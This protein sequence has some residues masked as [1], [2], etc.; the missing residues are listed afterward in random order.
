MT[1]AIRLADGERVDKAYAGERGRASDVLLIALAAALVAA[2]VF[3]ARW[4]YVWFWRREVVGVSRD[5][6]WSAPL[7][8]LLVWMPPALLVAPLARWLPRAWALRLSGFAF[9]TLTALSV[10]IPVGGL[11]RPAVGVLA[12]GIGVSVGRGLAAST[13]ALTSMRALSVACALLL[14]VAS[15]AFPQWERSQRLARRAPVSAPPAGARNVLVIVLDAVRADALGAYGASRATSPHLD[16]LARGGVRFATAVATAPWTRPTHRSIFTG[17]YPRLWPGGASTFLA[18]MDSDSAP[19]LAEW[20]AAHGYATGAFVANFFYTGWDA[21]FAAGFVHYRDFPRTTEQVLRT[22]TLGQTVMARALYDARS[23][24]DV[25]RALLA[26]DFSVPP[27]PLNADK[28]APLVTDEF[29]DWHA[30][31]GRQP[32]FAFLN[33]F[34]A[35]LPYDPPPPFRTRFSATPDARASYDGAV[36]FLDAEIGRLLR[37]LDRRGALD[38]TLVVITADHGELF[39]EHGFFEHT[40]NLYH[41]LLH[42]PLVLHLP[43]RVP[44]GVVV[45]QVASVRD[46]PATI[47]EL[48]LPGSAHPFPGVSLAGHWQADG[49]RPTSAAL[50]LVERGVRS[51]S[52][53]P[54]T[55]GDM[56]SL[57]DA[58][59]HFIRNYG[60]GREELYRY[61]EDPLESRDHASNGAADSVRARMRQQLDSLLRLHALGTPGTG[62]APSG[63]TR[64]RGGASRPQKEGG[65]TSIKVAPPT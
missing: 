35:H 43:Q 61:L 1:G 3:V 8:T 31:L 7:A 46:L 51:D 62:R 26:N 14:A 16:S 11:A 41:K 60:T 52:S 65:E 20:F 21:G 45:Q 6:G 2:L 17:E 64:V 9:F 49:G 22:S 63:T 44:A 15:L 40:S 37:E 58:T 29:L 50:A 48:A 13:R 36:A 33:Y 57:H 19:R 47:T 42:V 56:V 34:D 4:G 5:L 24:R 25:W 23:P 30:A 12:L 18:R 38:E 59:W 10:F 28:D 54:F 39:G 32:F 27:R 53:L 55:R